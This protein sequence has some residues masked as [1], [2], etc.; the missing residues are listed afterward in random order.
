MFWTCLA[1]SHIS[2]FTYHLRYYIIIDH[3]LTSYSKLC[4]FYAISNEPIEV[5]DLQSLANQLILNGTLVIQLSE[6]ARKTLAVWWSEKRS[7]Q[8]KNRDIKSSENHSDIWLSFFVKTV[9]G[10]SSKLFS[11]ISSI[12]DVWHGIATMIVFAIT[13]QMTCVS[14]HFVVQRP[15]S[16]RWT[17]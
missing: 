9:K 8:S 6:K 14:E 11:Q 5:A 12:I 1:F 10:S 2:H 15:K 4:Y 17:V 3:D 16:T 7:N 13:I